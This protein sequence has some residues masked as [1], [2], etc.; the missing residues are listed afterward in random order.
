M[1][2]RMMNKLVACKKKTGILINTPAVKEKALTL[3]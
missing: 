3:H 2:V 1:E